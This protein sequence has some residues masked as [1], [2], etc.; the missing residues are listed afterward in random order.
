VDEQERQRIG[1]DARLVDEVQVD[2]VELDTELL[3]RVELGL[4]RTPV[5]PVPPVLD[6][7]AHEG[8]V[9]AEPPA[10]AFDLVGPACEAESDPEVVEDLV[11]YVQAEP[12]R[13]RRR[14]VE[15]E[16]RALRP[17]LQPR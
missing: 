15:P 8:E 13:G 16:A 2:A 14:A 7:A 12:L 3:E 10:S 1:A 17:R 5:E 6:E 9:R 4:L 11:G